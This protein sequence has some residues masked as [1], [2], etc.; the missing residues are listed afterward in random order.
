MSNVIEIP[1]S[2]TVAVKIGDKTFT[3][4]AYETHNDLLELRQKILM[5]DEKPVQEFH[6]ATVEYLKGK[7]LPELNH[8]QADRLVTAMLK[9]VTELGK[10]E[11][12]AAV[13]SPT[14]ASPE[15]SEQAS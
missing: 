3:L 13:T 8:F 5:D 11:G 6:R 14:P 12:E 2:G 15:S 1:D 7:G 9:A 10:G 4:D